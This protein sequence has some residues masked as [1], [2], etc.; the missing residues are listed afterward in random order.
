MPVAHCHSGWFRELAAS[1]PPETA[2]A[3]SLG[4][5]NGVK[6]DALT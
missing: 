2:E 4:G 1:E 6:F 5:M 3:G